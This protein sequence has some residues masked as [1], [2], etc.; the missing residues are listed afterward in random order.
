MINTNIATD[1]PYLYLVNLYKHKQ[2]KKNTEK[3]HR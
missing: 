1:S 3:R 2:S